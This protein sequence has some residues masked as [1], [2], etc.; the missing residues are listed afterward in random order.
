MDRGVK[1]ELIKEVSFLIARNSRLRQ[2]IADEMIHRNFDK[3]KIMYLYNIDT[4]TMLSDEELF[5]SLYVCDKI[6]KTDLFKKYYGC[7]W[8]RVDFRILNEKKHSIPIR[9]CIIFSNTWLGYISINELFNN[10]M[11]ENPIIQPPV[12]I[13]AFGNILSYNRVPA[14][15]VDCIKLYYFNDGD[16]E[17]NNNYIG[18]INNIIIPYDSLFTFLTIKNNVQDGFLDVPVYVTKYVKDDTAAHH[19]TLC[20]EAVL[21]Y[22]CKDISSELN[23][24]IFNAINIKNAEQAVFKV[25][26]STEKVDYQNKIMM[27][28]QKLDYIHK[29]NST[30]ANL[31]NELRG[32][33]NK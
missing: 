25:V 32:L 7:S 26:T 16:I 22:I 5:L 1:T 2:S 30:T 17:K 13:Q 11:S 24:D 27:I 21:E 10:L 12:P 29:T 3:N 4:M 18:L 6:L 15:T 8:Q 20:K 33:F 19:R 28:A 9:N 23:Y 14:K 31:T